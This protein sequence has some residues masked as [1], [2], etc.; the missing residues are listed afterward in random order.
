M[1]L[2][3]NVNQEESDQDEIDGKR[4]ETDSTCHV[5]CVVDYDRITYNSHFHNKVAVL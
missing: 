1:M 5:S 3:D 2:E 4:Q